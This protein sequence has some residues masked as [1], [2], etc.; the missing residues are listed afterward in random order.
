MRAKHVGHNRWLW[1]GWEVILAC[2]GVAQIRLIDFDYGT[3]L[4]ELLHDCW[5]G[6]CRHIEGSM[7]GA[8]A[9]WYSAICAG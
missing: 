2:S 6:R 4:S 5:A 1:W 7:R 8:C 9:A 3:L